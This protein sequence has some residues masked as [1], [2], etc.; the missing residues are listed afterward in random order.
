MRRHA[1]LAL[2]LA[3]VLLIGA[4]AS[5]PQAS[6][7]RFHSQPVQRGTIYLR[8]ADPAMTNS[9]EFQA[10]ARPV[11]AQLQQQGFTVV[12]DPAQAQFTAVIDVSTSERVGAPRQSGLT[13][14]VGGGFSSGNVGI[15]TNVRVPVGGQPAPNVATTTTLKVAIATSP[16]NVAVWEGRATA[17]APA[18]SAQTGTVA[19]P[20][21]AG[22]LFR[23]FPGPSGRTVQVPLS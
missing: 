18:G 7:L 20:A 11:A 14:G 8:P 16:G 4:C 13:I 17:D 6:V 1:G 15:G 19:A 21:L 3:P 9:L 10:Q 12:A 23:D 22:A 2:A 5:T